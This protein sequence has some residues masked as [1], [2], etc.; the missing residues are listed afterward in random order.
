MDNKEKKQMTIFKSVQITKDTKEK[1]FKVQRGDINNKNNVS[2]NY[3]NSI[4]SINNSLNKN[5][6]NQEQTNHIFITHKDSQISTN[7]SHSSKK[8]NCQNNNN[9][10]FI[11]TMNKSCNINKKSLSNNN[12]KNIIKDNNKHMDES[13]YKKKLNLVY[14]ESIKKLCNHL[15]QNFNQLTHKEKISN[16][17]EYLAQM[18]QNLQILNK[19]IELIT[20]KQSFH[21]NKED[22]EILNIL[23]NHL[24]YMNKILNNNISK[25]IADIYSNLNNFCNIC[26]CS[27]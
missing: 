21:I 9:G 16:I 10:I 12:N 8:G 7:T 11:T 3:N 24:I 17:N 2:A 13:L 26:N 25:N 5:N 1:Y 20:N 6:D 18:Y 22:Y 15:N 23:L 27:T 14:F 19:K 4:N